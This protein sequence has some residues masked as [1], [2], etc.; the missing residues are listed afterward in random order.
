MAR[1]DLGG[2]EFLL[3]PF[4]RPSQFPACAG[5]PFGS[6]HA[7][8]GPAGRVAEAEPDEVGQ[9]VNENAREFLAGA[10]ERDAAFAEEGA[11]MDGASGI[12]KTARVLDADGVPEK[13]RQT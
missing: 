7:L 5:A 3:A 8:P 13:L 6:Q 9:F 1:A 2:A 4:G 12:A 10:I 11:A